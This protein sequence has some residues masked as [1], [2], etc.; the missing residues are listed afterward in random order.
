MQDEQK[1]TFDFIISCN[2][3][4]FSDLKKNPNLSFF[5]KKRY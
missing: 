3:R 5:G 2:I 1:Y 4:L